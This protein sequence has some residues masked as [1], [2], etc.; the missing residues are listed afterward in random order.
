MCRCCRSRLCS[1]KWFF[2]EHWRTCS[3]WFWSGM[4]CSRLV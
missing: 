2:C 1:K 4:C 3:L